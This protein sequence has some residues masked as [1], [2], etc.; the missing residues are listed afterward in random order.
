MKLLRFLGIGVVVGIAL[1]VL[2]GGYL[3]YATRIANPRVA[4]ELVENPDGERARR[5]MLLTLPSGRQIPVNYIR[6][7]AWV[8]AAADGTWWEEVVGDGFPVTL[9][10]RGETLTGR[11]RAVQDDSART[12]AV[13]ARLRPDALKGFGTLI[14]IAL[15]ETGSSAQ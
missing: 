5:V 4:R 9:L 10:V 1:A 8:Y 3:L 15:D 2:A 6:E 7:D 12:K 13:F 14:E 11:A